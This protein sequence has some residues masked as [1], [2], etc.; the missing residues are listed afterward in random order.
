M[1]SLWHGYHQRGQYH[2]LAFHLF[3]RESLQRRYRRHFFK[4]GDVD[5]IE[6]L[7]RLTGCVKD[8][9]LLAQGSRLFG[10][11]FNAEDEAIQV[12]GL[13]LHI[14]IRA[15]FRH[16]AELCHQPRGACHNQSDYFFVDWGHTE[17][18][19]Y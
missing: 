5:V 18:A 12:N 2:W 6:Q 14:M 13:K 16:G 3:E 7:V 15:G 10:A 9:E 4:V 11:H 17:K 1:R 19:W 8:R